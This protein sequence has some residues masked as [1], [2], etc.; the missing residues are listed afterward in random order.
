I[1]LGRCAGEGDADEVLAAV[2]P[3]LASRYP[4]VQT[5]AVLALGIHGSPR[6]VPLLGAIL[7]DTPAGREAV[8]GAG[9][10]P[11]RS[12]SAVAG[13]LAHHPGAVPLLTELRG[14]QPASQLELKSCAISALGC[15]ANDGA[16]DATPVLVEL[17][18]ARRLASPLKAQV[19]LALARLD[20]GT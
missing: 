6:F 20:N 10:P 15:T 14:T 9:P 12:L 13:G 18:R 8:G 2:R 3:L 5:S 17:L 1:A 4:S 16:A 19:P 11:V 7:S